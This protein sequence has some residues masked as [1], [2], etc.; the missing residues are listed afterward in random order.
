MRHARFVRRVGAHGQRIFAGS[1]TAQINVHHHLVGF[2]AVQAFADASAQGFP[3]PQDSWFDNYWGPFGDAFTKV[4]EG[5]IKPA[6]GV[7][8]ACADMDKANGK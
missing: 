1:E 5:Q 3:R 8:A 7:T 6:D 2:H 4:L